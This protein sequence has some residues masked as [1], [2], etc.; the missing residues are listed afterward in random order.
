MNRR[1][2]LK[3]PAA[4]GLAGVTAAGF[5]ESFAPKW[6]FFTTRPEEFVSKVGANYHGLNATIDIDHA[7]LWRA[8]NGHMY[9]EAE[10]TLQ[11]LSEHMQEHKMC[12]EYDHDTRACRLVEISQADLDEL[13]S[14]PAWAAYL[15]TPV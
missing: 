4:A 14:D 15:S 12:L 2:F 3:L 11:E 6:Q 5:S 10:M 7:L 13:S 1:E 8:E 9:V